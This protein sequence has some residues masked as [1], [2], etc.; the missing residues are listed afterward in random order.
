MLKNILKLNGAQEMSK[1]EL[2]TINGGGVWA[3][4]L[5]C[6]GATEGCQTV[7]NEVDQCWGCLDN[8]NN[9]KL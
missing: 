8:S 3:S 7:Y 1:K 2:Q 6:V 5:I 9:I 4:V